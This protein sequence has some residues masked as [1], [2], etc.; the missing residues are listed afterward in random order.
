MELSWIEYW[1]V[2]V[3]CINAFEQRI[4]ILK[5]I[6]HPHIMKYYT[7][8]VDKK[9]KRVSIITEAMPTQGKSNISN[10]KRCVID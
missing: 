6:D 8:W 10:L 1:N 4:P 5:R 2:P 3:R 7:A 9:L